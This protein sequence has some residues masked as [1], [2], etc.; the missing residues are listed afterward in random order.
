MGTTVPDDE[1]DEEPDE[2]L[3]ERLED[4]PPLSSEGFTLS[5]LWQDD[6]AHTRLMAKNRFLFIVLL[7]LKKIK[8]VAIV[9]LLF[10]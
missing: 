1:L 6:N 3:E 7:C 9:Y 5:N 8:N 2:E 4:D 10:R